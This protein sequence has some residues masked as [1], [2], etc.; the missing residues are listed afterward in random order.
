MP[1]IDEKLDLLDRHILDGAT[2]ARDAIIEKLRHESDE[3]LANIK[4]EIEREA[5]LEYQKD[6]VRAA[7]EKDSRVSKAN[8]SARKILMNARSD[9]IMSVL[10]DLAEKCAQFAATGPYREYLLKNIGEAL[11]RVG[12]HGGGKPAAG[13]Q[14]TGKPAAGAF[15]VYLTPAD[16]DKYYEDA[17]GAARGAEVRRGEAGM[18][19]GARTE[20]AGTGVYVDNTLKMKVDM[21]VD[22]LF[23]ISGLTINK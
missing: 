4:A 11:E 2:R 5:S 19:G 18:I 14:G 6:T 8:V 17:L 15:Y 20:N 16:Y 12:L 7:Y 22:D 23:Q 1:T 13:A 21:C 9:I 3:K 10:S